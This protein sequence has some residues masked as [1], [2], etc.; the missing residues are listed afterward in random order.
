MPLSHA[1]L[2]FLE[3]QPMSGYNLKKHFDRSVAHFWSA[4]Q[5]HIYKS[6]EILESEG[7]VKSQLIQQ[8][9]KPNQKQY[10]IT[11]AGRTEL[12]RWLSTPLPVE[13][14]RAAW[15]IQIF[16]AH[17]LA[18]E[19][20][21]SLFE[22]RIEYLR[23]YLSQLQ[24]AQKTMDENYKKMDMKRLQ[25]LWQLTLDYG[26][27]YYQHEINWLEETLTVVHKLPPL[28]LSTRQRTKKS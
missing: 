9:G 18:N 10:Q 3:Y 1:I 7:M 13:H 4:T 2:G 11:D 20:I 25:S 28:T 5:S 23:T 15:L 14:P 16:F 27:D 6:L 19:E 21:A 8:E 26:I 22:K 17:N 12:R 24:D